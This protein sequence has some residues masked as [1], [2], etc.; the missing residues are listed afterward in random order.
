VILA[1]VVCGSD[2]TF[3][4]Q[5]GRPEWYKKKEKEKENEN[6]VNFQCR[7]CYQKAYFKTSLFKQNYYLKNKIY[8]TLRRRNL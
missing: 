3:I 4:Q 6:I 8:S 2:K 7:S 5:N 1:V